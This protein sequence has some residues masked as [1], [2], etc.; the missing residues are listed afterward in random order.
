MKKITTTQKI[1]IIAFLV[2]SATLFVY[3]LIYK[4][5]NSM[6]LELNKIKAELDVMDQTAMNKQDTTELLEKSEDDIEELNKYFVPLNDPAVFL[7]TIESLGDY[8][9]TSVKVESLTSESVGKG[10]IGVVEKQ[11][12]SVGVA[13]DGEWDGVYRTLSLMEKMPYA[14]LINNVTIRSEKDSDYNVWGG[15]VNLICDAK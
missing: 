4:H 11:K 6:R 1:M 3:V 12:V 5:I 2:F 15:Y 7:E 14:I 9:G 10:T 13:L 8:T